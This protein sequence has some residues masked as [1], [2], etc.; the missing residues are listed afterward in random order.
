MHTLL[1]KNETVLQDSRFENKRNN[2]FLVAWEW[3]IWKSSLFKKYE[4]EYGNDNIIINI[5][6]N[7]FYEKIKKE[8][9]FNII[10]EQSKNF[11]NVK[12]RKINIFIDWLDEIDFLNDTSELIAMINQLANNNDNI[13]L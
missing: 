10:K 2:L 7:S 8:K 3:W 5:S 4:E 13:N 11:L 12:N 1:T 9:L 6:A